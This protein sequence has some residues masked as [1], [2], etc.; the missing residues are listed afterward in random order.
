MFNLGTSYQGQLPGSTGLGDRGSVAQFPFEGM[1]TAGFAICTSCNN[2]LAKETT[3]LHPMYVTMMHGNGPT[4]FVH[5]QYIICASCFSCLEKLT[6][7]H[8]P[9]CEFAAVGISIVSAVAAHVPESQ[10]PAK[11]TALQKDLFALPKEDKMYVF[12]TCMNSSEMNAFFS[13]IFSFWTSTLDVVATNLDR[14][15]LPYTRVDGTMSVMLSL[16][17]GTNE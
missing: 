8:Q 9:L 10:L 6:C 15:Q 7:Q 5:M 12:S 16:R 1:L 11:M 17:C 4:N 3:L 14:I 13:T 2:D